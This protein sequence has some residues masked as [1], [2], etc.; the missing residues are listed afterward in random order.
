V[1]S[2]LNYS[3]L[4]KDYDTFTIEVCTYR[5]HSLLIVFQKIFSE[6]EDPHSV[7]EGNWKAKRIPSSIF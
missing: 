5:D 3:E 2:P 7:L 6:G 4:S 1:I